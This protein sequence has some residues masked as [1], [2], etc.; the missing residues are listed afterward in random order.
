MQRY[1]HQSRHEHAVKRVRG[2]GGRFLTA[3]ER[4]E[5]NSE[6]DLDAMNT[7]MGESQDGSETP[8]DCNYDSSSQT[9][10]SNSPSCP[11]LLT[12]NN[13][14]AQR[15]QSAAFQPDKRPLCPM[16]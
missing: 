13:A 1:L 16:V 3:A 12:L 5:Q 14:D 11:S 4:A 9:S 7:G 15:P 2:P 8:D 6:A 10:G